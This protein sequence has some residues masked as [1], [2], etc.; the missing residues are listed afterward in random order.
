[1][2]SSVIALK[3]S[4]DSNHSP[5]SNFKPVVQR[6]PQTIAL[7]V[8]EKQ[9]MQLTHSL[10]EPRPPGMAPR[11][12]SKIASGPRSLETKWANLKVASALIQIATRT[13]VPL[14]CEF[15]RAQPHGLQTTVRYTRYTLFV[16]AYRFLLRNFMMHLKHKIEEAGAAGYILLWLLGIPVPILLLIFLLRGCS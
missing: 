15:V 7:D 14:C 4:Q 12:R 2:L 3:A 10:G 11:M 1:M 6:I 13:C 16:N 5:H 8:S 9:K